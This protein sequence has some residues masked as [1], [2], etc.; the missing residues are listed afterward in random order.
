MVKQIYLTEM[1]K[2]PGSDY[3]RVFIIVQHITHH[4]LKMF[5]S[6]RNINQDLK[7]DNPHFAQSK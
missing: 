5:N 2:T 6:K 1:F 3:I 4:L 7:R